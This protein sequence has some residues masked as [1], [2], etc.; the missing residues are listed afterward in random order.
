[1]R[2]RNKQDFWS[3]LMF[4]ALG[5][6]FAWK[7]SHYQLGTAARMGPGYFPF[8]LGAI[9]ALLGLVMLLGA[10]SKRADQTSIAPFN[11][12][13]LL[14][15]VGSVVVYALSLR[16]LGIYLSVLVLVLLSSL[17]SHE[18]NWKVS[19][20]NAIFL[21]AFTYLAFIKGLGLIFPLWPSLAGTH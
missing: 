2:L 20:A 3:G 16:L 18:F 17:A 5:L 14:L 6:G 8:W 12:R 15:V 19:L 1:M 13:I 21:V 7:A 10:L 4:V 9:L 11:W